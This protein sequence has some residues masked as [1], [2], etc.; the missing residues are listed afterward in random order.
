[1][2]EIYD[3]NNHKELLKL[4]LIH[5]LTKKFSIKLEAKKNFSLHQDNLKRIE[6]LLKALQQFFDLNKTFLLNG[7]I[8][9]IFAYIVKLKKL[10]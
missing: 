7:I 4:D 1:M 2:V 5:L 9:N 10:I 8:L 3:L 6:F